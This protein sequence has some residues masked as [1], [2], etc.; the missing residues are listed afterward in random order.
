MDLSK[1]TE[2]DITCAWL[3]LKSRI[4][5][6][7]IL[8]S[9]S[10]VENF[11]YPLNVIVWSSIEYY[12]CVDNAKFI[13]DYNDIYNIM[14]GVLSI[15]EEWFDTLSNLSKDIIILYYKDKK[16][17][18]SILDKL[19]IK[20]LNEAR[21]LSI[22]N[23]MLYN[24]HKL[25]CTELN[26]LIDSYLINKDMINDGARHFLETD[27]WFAIYDKEICILLNSEGYYTVGDIYSKDTD[28]DYLTNIIKYTK[29]KIT[30]V[31]AHILSRKEYSESIVTRIKEKYIDMS[32]KKPQ[33]F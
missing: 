7:D 23:R 18:S 16:P 19:N 5:K 33:L 26:V 9:E 25:L 15:Y 17:L 32:S 24:L 10:S 3:L 11:Q 2:D 8:I 12:T 22:K 21:V 20:L 14:E 1:F 29:T 13:K 27:I 28:K 30:H 6:P 31:L 4:I